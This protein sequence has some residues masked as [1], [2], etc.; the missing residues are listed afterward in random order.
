MTF[1][2]YNTKYWV[3]MVLYMVVYCV[4]NVICNVICKL[5]M[6]FIRSFSLDTCI[7]LVF[8]YKHLYM[9]TSTSMIIVTNR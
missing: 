6:R 5:N 3:Y 7:L 2:Y 4:Y 1:E 9:Y 8:I